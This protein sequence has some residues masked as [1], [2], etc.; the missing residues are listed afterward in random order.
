MIS[1]LERRKS[2]LNEESGSLTLLLVLS[3]RGVWASHGPWAST[4]SHRC[5][6]HLGQFIGV[7][8]GGI[9]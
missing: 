3:L 8:R 4:A 1:K 5:P 2:C 7:R 9:S 6:L